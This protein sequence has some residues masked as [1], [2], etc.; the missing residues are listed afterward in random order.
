MY[1]IPDLLEF[2]KTGAHFG[3]QVSKWHPKMK[4]FIFGSRNGIHI[5]DLEQTV[6][7]L[8]EA[9]DAARDMTAKGG[10]IVFLG[11]KRQAAP[12]VEKY[13]KACGA[14]Y[15]TTRWLGGTFTNFPELSKLI[16]L[17]TTSPFEIRVQTVKVAL[18]DELTRALARNWL[19]AKT[20]KPASKR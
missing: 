12:I 13:A 20:S 14:P 18:P 8:K 4:P 11:T 17:D 9:L 19:D 10:V 1:E 2:L 3:H 15:I 5:I 16:K 6:V 7:K